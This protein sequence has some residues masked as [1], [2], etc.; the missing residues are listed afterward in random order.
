VGRGVAGPPQR[1]GAMKLAAWNQAAGQA[2]EMAA[3]QFSYG[4]PDCSPILP[5]AYAA[6]NYNRFEPMCFGLG[7]AF[8][9][10]RPSL[11]LTCASREASSACPRRTPQ[12]SVTA[13]GLQVG[14]FWSNARSK[15]Y[16][17]D[18]EA[19]AGSRWRPFR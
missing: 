4:L 12:N 10:C 1:A 3:A 8:R 6:V 17:I 15:C 9:P 7:E 14:W 2:V 13:P 19:L 18:F 11:C 16:L 5:Q